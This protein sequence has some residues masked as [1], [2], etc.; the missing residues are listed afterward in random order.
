MCADTSSFS[1]SCIY[2]LSSLMAVKKMCEISAI[3]NSLQQLHLSWLRGPSQLECT[4]EW[5]TQDIQDQ[6]Q[7]QS[8]QDIQGQERSAPVQLSLGVSQIRQ[9]YKTAPSS[10]YSFCYRFLG[11]IFNDERVSALSHLLHLTKNNTGCGLVRPQV[12]HVMSQGCTRSKAARL[13][14][15]DTQVVH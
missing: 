10:V 4:C 12:G 8:T 15:P 3:L 9:N 13:V 14:W 2:S 5:D 1:N 11:C 6:A 7:L